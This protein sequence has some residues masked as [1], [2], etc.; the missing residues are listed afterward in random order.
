MARQ[1]MDAR[2]ATIIVN[3]P[4]RHAT[5]AL[6]VSAGFAYVLEAE[7]QFHRSIWFG[8]MFAGITGAWFILG[9]FL[10][11][12]D[13]IAVWWTAVVLVVLALGLW[14]VGLVTVAPGEV[15][16]V[17]SL[18]EPLTV[19]RVLLALLVGAGAALTFSMRRRRWPG[20]LVRH[21]TAVGALVLVVG[22]AATTG[23][24][25]AQAF[26]LTGDCA[27]TTQPAPSRTTATAGTPQDEHEPTSCGS[28]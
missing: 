1:L 15:D 14:G 4:L 22:L 3:S 5:G 6:A 11:L 8:V 17:G 9:S 24:A 28:S 16:D 10:A 23:A 27:P 13:A 20:W 18:D 21:S 12:I 25:V 7:D 2:S 26:S 19:L